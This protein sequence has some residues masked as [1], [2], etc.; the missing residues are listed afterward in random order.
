MMQVGINNCAKA[1]QHIMNFIKINNHTSIIL[2][3]VPHRYDLM[4]SSCVNSEII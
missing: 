2:L 3:T 1:L 4:R